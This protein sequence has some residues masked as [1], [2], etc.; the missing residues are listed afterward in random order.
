LKICEIL[1]LDPRNAFDAIKYEDYL[2]ELSENRIPEGD[3]LYEDRFGFRFSGHFRTDD[4]WLQWKH[5]Y[6][7]ID[8]L[9][10]FIEYQLH[11]TEEIRDK[12]ERIENALSS[13]DLQAEHKG[14]RKENGPDRD[15]P[16]RSETSSNNQ[17][18]VGAAPSSRP[19]GGD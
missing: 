12:L 1:E 9:N 8:D 5:N 14:Q 6:K 18:A 15:D 7:S 10:S 3:T 13:T 4:D 2:F 16:S 19:K 11:Y 17:E